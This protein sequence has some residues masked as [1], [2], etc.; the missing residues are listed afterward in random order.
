MLPVSKLR[1]VSCS[2]VLNS[3][4][5]VSDTLLLSLRNYDRLVILKSLCSFDTGK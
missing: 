5:P 3:L 4:I 2:T 1:R